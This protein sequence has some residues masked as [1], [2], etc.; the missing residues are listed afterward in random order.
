M[1]PK[2][3]AE[4][5]AGKKQAGAKTQKQ[6]PKQTKPNQEAKAAKPKQQQKAGGEAGAAG[7]SKGAGGR[8]ARVPGLPVG[9]LLEVPE[10]TY[11]EVP[12]GILPEATKEYYEDPVLKGEG[13]HEPNYGCK[14]VQAE[15]EFSGRRSLMARECMQQLAAVVQERTRRQLYLDGWA[16]SGKS[17]ALYSLVAWARAQGWLALYLPSAFSLVQTGTFTRGEDGLWDTPEAARWLLSSLRDSH[18]AQL[19]DV[20]AP[21]GQ[22]LSELVE[23]GLAAGA[24]PAAVVAAAIAAKEAV[25]ASTELPTLIAVDDYNVLYSHTG[26]HESLHSFH[27]RQLAPDELRLVRAFRVL[28][29][30]PP[31]NGVVVAAPTF[32][33]LVSDKLRVPRARQARFHVPRYCLP[34]VESAADYFVSEVLAGHAA[35]PD[36]D[37]LL[38]ALFLTNGNARELRDFGPAL[39]GLPDSPLGLSRGYKADAARRRAHDAGMLQ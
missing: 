32:G 18:A 6:Q 11:F 14:A 21:S 4:Q 20:K 3:K 13:V 1:Q 23:E 19:P 36:D 27:R 34:E 39:L 15:W 29:Q 33:Q 5:Q 38:R 17:V 2:Q 31:A 28:E 35:P 24:K 30:P 25:A 26:Y 10:G 16:G 9:R 22:P 12:Q 37:T 8:T 7:S